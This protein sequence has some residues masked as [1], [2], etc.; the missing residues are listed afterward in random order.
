MSLEGKVAVITGAG[1]GIGLATARL[2][3][4]RGAAVVLAERDEEKGSTAAAA[5][6]AA[7]GRVFFQPTDV[8]EFV[9][10]EA[11]VK[12]AVERFGRL[13]IMFNNAGAGLFK[14]MLETE[15]DEFD[16]VVR[17]NLHGVYHG[18]LA[19]GRVMRDL[20]IAGVIINT[21][22]V[23]AYIASK[24]VVGYH[25]A[26]GGVVSL[27]QA[28]AL[29]LAPLGIRVVGVAPGTVNT[30]IIQ[31]YRDMGMEDRLE[32]AQMRRKIIEPEKVAEVVAF[33]AT[34]AADAINGT[35]LPVDDGLLSFKT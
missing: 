35:T 16:L 9:Q 8:C 7:G 28:A 22:S 29:E 5:L 23:Y 6:E 14:P 11:A 26:K 12:C 13:D 20:S 33:L 2:F 3:V 19:A 24:G 21:A 18:I 25:A 10:V 30:P 15:P 34:D 17:I 4:Q 1:S 32:K 27:T 31:S